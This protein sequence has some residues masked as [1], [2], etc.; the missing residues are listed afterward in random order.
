MKHLKR[1]LL[2]Q[3]VSGL[4]LFGLIGSAYAAEAITENAPAAEA[5]LPEYTFLD[6]LKGGK[7]LTSFRLRYENVNQ[8]GFAQEANGVTL[9]SL[10]GWQTA[11]YKNFS[12]AAQF[13]N[14][15][16]F[17]DD[18]NDV[19]KGLPQ[20]GHTQYPAIVDPDYTDVN[21]LFVEWTGIK[22]TKIRAGR[23]SLKL[24][25]V[26]MIGNIEFRQVMQ[27]FDGIALENKSLP[28]TEIYLADFER[29]K[30]I[31]TKLRDSGR[32]GIV[33]VKYR[34]SPS[35]SLVGYANFST[36]T[37]LGFGNG[38]FGAG[39]ANADQSNV[40][41][42]ARLDGVRKFNDDWKY[43]YTAEFAKQTRFADGDSRINA[44]YLRLGGGAIYDLK[45]DEEA[46]GTFSLRLDHE[47][48]SS[49]G[50]RFGFQTPF[51]TNHLF[52]GWVDKFL[53]TPKEGIQDTFLTAAY[54]FRDL[55]L[56]TEFHRINSDVG[57]NR[58]GGGTGHRYGNEWDLSAA[59]AFDKNISS[60][61]EYG[62][63]TEGDRY[64]AGRIRSTDKLW[65]TAM[66]AF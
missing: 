51:G 24:D 25:N 49:N 58:M 62:R 40:I 45:I 38:W 31:N 63:F 39:N 23:Q 55:T 14:V 13:I 22:N 60:K 57:F 37:D 16:K 53:V 47:T 3:A 64:A 19:A 54:K 32:L 30:Q 28:D 12:I 42:G 34:I 59:Y 44:H 46:Y 48:L 5:P 52:Q 33:N 65:L 66:Y 27:V 11:P 56:S 41:F 9:R 6:A 1:N 4:I 7:N 61:V 35:E 26:R 43:A 10:I 8:D 18:Y 20:P 36:F 17:K 50:G 29:I 21:Q 15:S 2:Q